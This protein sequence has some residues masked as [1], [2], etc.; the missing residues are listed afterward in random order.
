MAFPDGSTPRHPFLPSLTPS[1]ETEMGREGSGSWIQVKD[2]GPGIPDYARGRVFE[3]FYSLPRP[4]G[5][6]KS[7]GLGLTL[8]QEIAALHG[9]RVEIIRSDSRGT[10]I[11]MFFGVSRSYPSGRAAGS[12]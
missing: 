6:K 7:S 1:L 11:Q 5:G 2:H 3:R 9:G 12:P 8:T 10:V 4:E